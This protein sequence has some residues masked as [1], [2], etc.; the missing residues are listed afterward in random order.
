[1]STQTAGSSQGQGADMATRAH[2]ARLA[3]RQLATTSEAVRNEALE[4]IAAAL[5]SEREDLLRA[6]RADLE[7]GRE[8]VNRGEM[9]EPLL[10]RL[11]LGGAKFGGTV[12]M[13]R[14][15]R[16]QPEPLGRTQSAMEL[17]EGLRLYRV[18]VPIGVLAVI[19]ESRPDALVQIA[20]LCLKSGN[21]VLMKGGREA[22]QSNQ[23][24]AEVITRASADVEGIPQGW[25]CLLE[26]RDDVRNMLAEHESID[27]VIPRGSNEFVQYIMQNTKIPVMGHAD[28]LCHVYVDRAAD[29]DRAVRITVDSKTQYVAVCNAA[30]TQLVHAD[31][32]ADFLQRAIPTLV[33]AKVELR[34]DERVVEMAGEL[35]PV[36]PAAEE[37]WSTEY[38]DYILSIR[39]VDSLE[40]AVEHINRYGS[41]HTDTIVTEDAEAASRFLMGVDSASVFH[42]ASTRFADGYKYGLGA[43]VGISTGRLHSRGPV[44]LEGLTSYKYLLEGNGQT[45]DDFEGA[46]PRP[47]SHRPLVSTWRRREAE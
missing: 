26:T 22:L 1:M 15:V 29:E 33:Q 16:D 35:G 4:A 6:N 44:G 36:S 19:F 8:L 32:A 9:G 13:V 40:E 24:L 38:L 23:A 12:E 28:G 46:V 5:E 31:V 41:S 3:S 14:S 42:N 17:A 7:L 37:D 45:V 21:A 27:L 43:E 47:F 11:D 18:S 10:K 30:E 25:L 34:G 20:C 2:V 39:I